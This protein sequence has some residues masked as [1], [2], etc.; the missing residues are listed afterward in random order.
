IALGQP[1]LIYRLPQ[2][3]ENVALH[4]K[5][6]AAPALGC[7]ENPLDRALLS[8]LRCNVAPEREISKVDRETSQSL[9]DGLLHLSPGTF[10]G[11]MVGQVALELGHERTVGWLLDTF[12]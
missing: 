2:L 5:K 3:R 8:F 4:A 9:I 1:P 11:P 10:P 12:L 6:I 7:S